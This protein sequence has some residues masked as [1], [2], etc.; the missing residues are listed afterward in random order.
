MADWK[1]PQVS[2]DDG[3]VCTLRDDTNWYYRNNK[4]R[5]KVCRKGDHPD[6]AAIYVQRRSAEVLIESGIPFTVAS[7]DGSDW[8]IPEVIAAKMQD[9]VAKRMEYASMVTLDAIL[10]RVKQIHFPG[11]NNEFCMEC[12]TVYPCE[13]MRAI[14]GDNPK[15]EEMENDKQNKQ[16]TKPSDDKVQ[17]IESKE[18]N[19]VSEFRSAVESTETKEG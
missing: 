8:P 7:F 2:H 11:E 5:E 13:T 12:D 14:V 10:H 3:R 18:G 19:T 15:E 6:G 17:R 4:G 1:Q 9:F 16:E